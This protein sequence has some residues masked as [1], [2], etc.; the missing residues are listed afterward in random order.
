[1]SNNNLANISTFEQLQSGQNARSGA[2]QMNAF[3][4]NIA[5][6]NSMADVQ[7]AYSTLEKVHADWKKAQEAVKKA[8]EVERLFKVTKANTNKL[9]KGEYDRLNTILKQNPNDDIAQKEKQA[10]ELLDEKISV[11]ERQ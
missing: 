2:S 6:N 7:K 10:L 4:E 8:D 1:M 11:I 3:Q 5:V 9:V